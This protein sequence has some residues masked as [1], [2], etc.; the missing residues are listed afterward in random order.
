MN[1]SRGSRASFRHRVTATHYVVPDKVGPRVVTNS[2]PSAGSGKIIG[3]DYGSL[4][5]APKALKHPECKGID[6]GVA[7]PATLDTVGGIANA[8]TLGRTDQAVCTAKFYI[9]K[10]KVNVD[11]Y[12]WYLSA[13]RLLPEQVE[14]T[15]SLVP[16]TTL[17]LRPEQGINNLK[18][19]RQRIEK[20]LEIDKAEAKTNKFAEA[21][22]KVNER[23]LHARR[24]I[25]VI[26]TNEDLDHALMYL[27]TLQTEP[28]WADFVKGVTAAVE[29]EAEVKFEAAQAKA[30]KLGGVQKLTRED[31]AGLSYEQIKQLRGY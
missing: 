6:E 23:I 12:D 19:L 21:K 10:L 20:Q 3:N 26:G 2:K 4:E 18:L 16:G 31:I 27:D 8:I 28:Q 1:P 5:S 22:Q 13:E 30:K 11:K 14:A 24:L 7:L 25:D 29:E 17:Y 9:D 15:V